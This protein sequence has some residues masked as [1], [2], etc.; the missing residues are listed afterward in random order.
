MNEITWVGIN[1]Y[2]QD[3]STFY[4]DISENDVVQMVLE[5]SNPWDKNAV[6][7]YYNYLISGHISRYDTCVVHQL[8]RSGH[9]LVGR[10]TDEIDR[11]DNRIVISV[12]SLDSVEIPEEEFPVLDAPQLGMD[13]VPYVMPEEVSY[14][15][16]KTNVCTWVDS[17][18]MLNPHE[19]LAVATVRKIAQAVER[20]LAIWNLSLSK[21]ANAM[22]TFL[23]KMLHGVMRMSDGMAEILK[24]VYKRLKHASGSQNKEKRIVGVFAEQLKACFEKYN[25]E[26]GVFDMFRKMYSDKREELKEREARIESWLMNLPEKVGEAY[27]AGVGMFAH[28][29]YVCGFRSADLYMIYAHL[30]MLDLTRSLLY[31]KDWKPSVVG[32]GKNSFI[33]MDG[34]S[35]NIYLK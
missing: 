24:D 1:H 30:L 17:L 16:I 8:A 18:K 21:E 33:F 34:A 25:A 19:E 5:P 31:G 12:E 32:V 26:N 23:L 20:Y 7:V 29:L 15:L 3:L 10:V 22:P 13:L 6:A 27:K 2:V 9:L 11:E 14:G 35:T 4:D 28:K